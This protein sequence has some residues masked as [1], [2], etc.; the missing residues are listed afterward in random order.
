MD[1]T[2]MMEYLHTHASPHTLNAYK[3]IN[4]AY[5]AARADF[6]RYV[7]MYNEGGVYLDIKSS[8]SMPFD[9]ILRKDDQ[10]LL[11]N[12]PG[13]PHKYELFTE[14]DG[15]GEYLNWCIITKPKHPY[16][17]AV[18]DDV[19]QLID[20]YNHEYW[21]EDTGVGMGYTVLS[22]TGPIAYTRAIAKIRD[23]YP[24][25]LYHNYK[26][27]GLQYSIFWTWL[28]FISSVLLDA[29]IPIHR[30]YT[31]GRVAGSSS[32]CQHYTNKKQPLVF[33]YPAKEIK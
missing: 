30:S 9:R 5:G 22:I 18:I 3:K 25:T 27:I 21:L 26:H 17:K 13:K 12:W 23:K 19:I 10:F 31:Y 16:L 4:P 20:S 8:A 1:D 33:A 24:H 29:E 6:F 28:S 11:L 32:R 15:Y 14:T 7:L 2:D